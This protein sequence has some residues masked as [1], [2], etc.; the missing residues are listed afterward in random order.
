M[1]LLR[2]YTASRVNGLPCSC[3]RAP[4]SRRLDS[5]PCP[6]GG[7]E[8]QRLVRPRQHHRSDSFR[9]CPSA[10][11][12]SEDQHGEVVDA[13]VQQNRDGNQLRR[14]SHRR[15]GAEVTASAFTRNATARSAAR[16]IIANSRPSCS[17]PTHGLPHRSRRGGVV[18]PSRQFRRSMPAALGA[19]ARRPPPQTAKIADGRQLNCTREEMA[20]AARTPSAPS[21]G[22]DCPTLYSDA[23]SRLGA[24]F[25]SS[26]GRRTSRRQAGFR[27][28]E[29]P[30]PVL[31]LSGPSA[32]T[33]P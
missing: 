7:I 22:P 9:L 28:P 8:L 5:T 1:Y 10:C 24:L 3:G 31:A 4:P 2:S 27:S 18:A 23:A 19:E 21:H 25:A 15:S 14:T 16:E 32:F 12:D 26:G 13:E 30:Q 11:G 17:R 6:R 33:S 29:V 20:F